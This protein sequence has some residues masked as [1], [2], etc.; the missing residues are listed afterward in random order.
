M[1]KN[2]GESH[3]GSD[4]RIAAEKHKLEKKLAKQQNSKKPRY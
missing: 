1:A 2:R 4:S 3:I